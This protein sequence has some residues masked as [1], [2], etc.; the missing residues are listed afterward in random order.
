LGPAVDASGTLAD[1]RSFTGPEGLVELLAAD[2]ERLAESFVAHLS[3]Y[4]TGADVGYAD[5]AEIRRIVAAARHGDFGLRTLVHGVARSRLLGAGVAR[6][7]AGDP[8]WRRNVAA[9]P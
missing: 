8:R 4:A 6:E 2:S 9:G 1:G 3:R 7:E 5:R